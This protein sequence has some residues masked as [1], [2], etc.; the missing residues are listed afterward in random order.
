MVKSRF[1]PWNLSI[2]DRRALIILGDFVV[3]VIAL[4]VSLV[5]WATVSGEWLGFSMAFFQERVDFWFYLL[6]VGW[7]LLLVEAYDVHR[8]A[9]LQTTIQGIS[10]AAGVGL[11]P[12]AEL[13]MGQDR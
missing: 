2:S 7:I 12:L 4:V 13:P 6:P 8:A 1:K 5:I 10:S 3:A 11:P 9:N